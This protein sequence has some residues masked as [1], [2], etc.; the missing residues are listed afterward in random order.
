MEGLKPRG[1]AAS[2]RARPLRLGF[3]ISQLPGVEHHLGIGRREEHLGKH[4]VRIEGDR[5]QQRFK[6]LGRQGETGLDRAAAGSGGIVAGGLA[7]RGSRGVSRFRRA[8]GAGGSLGPQPPAGRRAPGCRRG[9]VTGADASDAASLEYP[10]PFSG[11]PE[12]SATGSAGILSP[13]RHE[14][15]PVAVARPGLWSRRQSSGRVAA[16]FG[17]SQSVRFRTTRRFSARPSSVLLSAIGSLSPAPEA[18]RRPDGDALAFQVRG[19]RRGPPLGELLV[20]GLASPSCPCGR[21]PC[22]RRTSARVRLVATSSSVTLSSSVSSAEF[23]LNCTCRVTS[24]EQP[25]GPTRSPFG[26]SGHWSFAVDD[27][28]AVAVGRRRR[29]RRR[30]G[31]AA[32]HRRGGNCTGTGL[33]AEAVTHLGLVDERIDFDRAEV[34]HR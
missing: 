6:G 29:G 19:H 23:S 16:Y 9:F 34:A 4:R 15:A 18:A 27:A 1:W 13:L 10:S 22:R 12:R 17:A 14:K 26:V 32:T 25:W 30:R 31:R 7:R 11:A 21:P 5:R 33:P 3:W 28:V 8:A 24:Q 20:V 2:S